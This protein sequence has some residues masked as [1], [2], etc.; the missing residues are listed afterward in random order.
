MVALLQPSIAVAIPVLLVVV[1]AGHS[2][3]TFAG[4]IRLGLS[5]SRTVMSCVPLVLFP[6]WSTAVHLR[7]RSVVPPQFVVVLSLYVMVTEPQPSCAVATPVK[8]VIVLVE[9]HSSTKFAGSTR[10]G[11][12][13]SRTVMV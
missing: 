3:T 12:V 9:G 11:G 10:V 1:L 8:L 6:H 4:T 5:V 13:M 7:A 2:S